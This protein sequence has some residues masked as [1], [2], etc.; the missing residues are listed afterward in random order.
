MP[1]IAFSTIFRKLK[2]RI[3]IFQDIS[4]TDNHNLNFFPNNYSSD[5]NKQTDL[6][7]IE[8]K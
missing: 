7:F 4:E 5:K 3:R 1:S 6:L 8:K 2:R